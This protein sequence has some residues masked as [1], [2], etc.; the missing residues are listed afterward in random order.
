[1]KELLFVTAGATLLIGCLAS[2]GVNKYWNTTNIEMAEN[3]NH[4]NENIPVET[5]R[6]ENVDVENE[7]NE[8]QS[9]LRIEDESDADLKNLFFEKNKDIW[10][11]LNHPE[12]INENSFYPESGTF[13]EEDGHSLSDSF[14]DISLDSAE[15]LFRRRPVLPASQ[16]L[17]PVHSSIL[18]STEMRTLCTSNI[19]VSLPADYTPYSASSTS[20]QV[21][22]SN[23]SRSAMSIE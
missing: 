17:F 22:C 23:S 20:L 11:W 2:Y 1:M 8:T 21:L 10:K 12:Y 16:N 15:E 6:S 14:S 13:P 4:R 3:N 19:S 9:T 7:N 18:R 5:S